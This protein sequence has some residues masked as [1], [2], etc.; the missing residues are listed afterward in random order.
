[1]GALCPAKE[2][3]LA[4]PRPNDFEPIGRG[5]MG[6]DRSQQQRY[7]HDELSNA[8]PST[9]RGKQF[10]TNTTY[11][12]QSKS[13]KARI[14]ASSDGSIQM[15]YGSGE[16]FQWSLV[17][18]GSGAGYKFVNAATSGTLSVQGDRV[19][20]AGGRNCL[21]KPMT[22]LSGFFALVN[23]HL[24][25]K[26]QVSQG[27]VGL[28]T[29]STRTDDALWQLIDLDPY[30][31]GSANLEHAAKY[32]MELSKERSNQIDKNLETANE[33][34]RATGGLGRSSRAVRDMYK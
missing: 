25:Q 3:V 1:M 23:F 7:E 17:D 2:I 31:S 20:I 24:T 29:I 6:N 15:G 21:W 28:A 27:R 5:N 34:E 12:L 33:L 10:S 11:L 19:M 30:H 16:E 13:E 32:C 4:P 22:Q 9:I 14:Q 8:V 18:D 26:L